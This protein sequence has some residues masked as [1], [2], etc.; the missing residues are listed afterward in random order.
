MSKIALKK[1]CK[2]ILYKYDIGEIIIDDD[3]IFLLE[4]INKHPFKDQKIG[5][6]IEYFYISISEYKN[7]M[8]KIMR[9]DGSNTDFSYIICIDGDYSNY[10]KFRKA[11]RYAIKDQILDF[12]AQNG[13]IGSEGIDIHHENLE[14][15]VLVKKFIQENNIDV[16]KVEFTAG[17]DNQTNVQFIDRELAKKFRQEHFNQAQLAIIKREDHKKI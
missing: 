15:E 17:L 7:R 14:F 11:C 13:L 8:F 10:K 1:K 2:E 9:T 12:K 3:H 6:G 16:N 4:L 5:C